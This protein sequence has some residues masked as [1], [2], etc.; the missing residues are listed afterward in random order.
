MYDVP[1]TPPQILSTLKDDLRKITFTGEKENRIATTTA[2]LA[3]SKI[4]LLS[5][6]T[7]ILNEFLDINCYI[8][9]K[10]F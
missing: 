9:Y 1:S 7:L 10:A 6:N 5:I 2:N 8:Y 4:T 3:S